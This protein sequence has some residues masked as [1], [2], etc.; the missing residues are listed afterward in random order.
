MNPNF[1]VKMKSLFRYKVWNVYLLL[2][3]RASN[4]DGSVE[5]LGRL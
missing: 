3:Y 4:E 2:C 1:N 5:I